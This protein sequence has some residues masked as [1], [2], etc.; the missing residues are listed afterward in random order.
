MDPFF[1]AAWL[2]IIEMNW[3]NVVHSYWFNV[4]CVCVSLLFVCYSNWFY[5]FFC[6][7]FFFLLSLISLI[8]V[9]NNFLRKKY[10][11]NLTLLDVCWFNI[12]VLIIGPKTVQQKQNT[13]NNC[14]RIF[15]GSNRSDFSRHVNHKWLLNS[16]LYS[17]NCRIYSTY[18]RHWIFLIAFFTLNIFPS[19]FHSIHLHCAF[20]SFICYMKCWFKKK[21]ERYKNV[22]FFCLTI[23]IGVGTFFF[24]KKL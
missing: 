14:I 8:L 6:S 22:D 9:V 18:P 5:L 13:E 3:I 16:W 23:D 2:Y 11:M 17:A 19:F 15:N 12:T 1:S 20:F 24:L 10:T 4:V 7:V 21:Y